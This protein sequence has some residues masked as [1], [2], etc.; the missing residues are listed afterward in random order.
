MLSTP[1]AYFRRDWIRELGPDGYRADV[2]DLV[3]FGVSSDP[4]LDLKAEEILPIL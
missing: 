2:I 3:H 1:V 4:S